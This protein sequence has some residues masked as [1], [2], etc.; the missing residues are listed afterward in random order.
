MKHAKHSE[1]VDVM[2]TQLW[3]GFSR[4]HTQDY[5]VSRCLIETTVAEMSAEFRELKIV[6]EMKT[7]IRLEPEYWHDESSFARSTDAQRTNYGLS[8]SNYRYK[9]N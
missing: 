7:L 9:A 2:F 4:P 6:D 3:C 5:L 1:N 8:I